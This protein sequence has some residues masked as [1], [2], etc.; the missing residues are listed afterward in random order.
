MNW[1]NLRRLLAGVLV[2]SLA[3]VAMPSG[4]GL[5]VDVDDELVLASFQF[6]SPVRPGQGPEGRPA[7]KLSREEALDRLRSVGMTLPEETEWLRIDSRLD[8]Y[9]YPG[10]AWEFSVVERRGHV[11]N[12]FHLARI[13]ANTGRILSYAPRR[14]SGPVS[15]G[16]LSPGPGEEAAHGKAWSLL[17]TIIG[18][19]EAAALKEVPSREWQQGTWYV[20]MPE[21]SGYLHLFTWVRQHNGVPVR[22]SIVQVGLDRSTL[23]LVLYTDTL[24]DNVK[25]DSNIPDITAAQ[26]MEQWLAHIEPELA[27]YPVESMGMGIPYRQN[28]PTMKLVYQF[29]AA[30]RP[31]DAYTGEFTD[32]DP[33]SEALNQKPRP[34][35]PGTLPAFTPS[36]LPLTDAA[37]RELG[38]KLLGLPAGSEPEMRAE[39]END[40]IHLSWDPSFSGVGQS[41]ALERA[42][43]VPFYGWRRDERHMKN[44]KE[45]EAQAAASGAEPAAPPPVTREQEEQARQVALAL[46]DQYF[47]PIRSQLRLLPVSGQ[48][49]LD[50][51]QQR[52]F[53]FVRYVNGVRVSQDGLYVTVDLASMQWQEFH[54]EWT[55]VAFPPVESILTPDAVLARYLEG[56]TPRLVYQPRFPETVDYERGP[57][58]QEAGLVYELAGNAESGLVD[59]HTGEALDWAGEPLGALDRA[60]AS[61]RGHWAEGALRYLMYRRLLMPT[62][63]DPGASVARQEAVNLILQARERNFY[64]GDEVR[65]LP[66]ADIEKGSPLFALLGEAYSEGWL[67]PAAAGEAFRP[68]DPV[69]RAQFVLWMA[70]ALGLGDLTRSDMQVQA[71][72]ADLD[73]LTAE[74]RNAAIFLQAMGLLAPAKTFRGRDPL[75]Q[76]EAAVLTVR[77]HN[78]L[79]PE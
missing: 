50:P 8:D 34:L 31:I 11:H 73:G 5:A 64:A 75:T 20:P 53:T 7:P 9:G 54:R 19:Q 77:L 36:A 2:A 48:S 17:S 13:D 56:R 72:Y 71:R 58:F 42:T 24:L 49:F 32:R 78:H 23:D 41:V 1:L 74:E 59:A 14:A 22:D 28:S 4:V 62:R 69:T 33:L 76:A 44:M 61:I 27:Y 57:R 37:A 70:R 51:L 67:R 3:A 21:M 38:A 35:G 66:F 30:R 10:P 79:L 43:G 63:V 6:E 12:W 29:G 16:P 60:A 25:F 47:A 68:D 46:V 45:L 40:R 55:G 39:P 65:Q 52:Q 26:A 18:P 15:T